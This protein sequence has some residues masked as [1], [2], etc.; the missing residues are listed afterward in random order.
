MT[1]TTLIMLIFQTQD[2][3]DLLKKEKVNSS[4]KLNETHTYVCVKGS[5]RRC[6]LGQEPRSL[7]VLTP[8]NKQFSKSVGWTVPWVGHD[9]G[10]KL[11]TEDKRQTKT[12]ERSRKPINKKD[13]TSIQYHQKTSS[14][15][16]YLD[17]P[18][19]FLSWEIFDLFE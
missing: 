14:L 8:Q 2:K 1:F 12:N 6:G 4:V 11:Q 5:G 10:R 15:T 19:R 9:K 7:V 3:K 16:R 13:K 17:D 18:V